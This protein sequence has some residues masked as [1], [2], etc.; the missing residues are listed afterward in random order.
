MN[1]PEKNFK[2]PDE[3]SALEVG[4]VIRRQD[5]DFL[6]YGFDEKGAFGLPVRPNLSPISFQ[7]LRDSGETRFS[8]AQ[9]FETKD[10][11]LR[12]N[13]N[14]RTRLETPSINEVRPTKAQ[15]FT[16]NIGIDF[17]N[18]IYQ[19]TFNTLSFGHDS[20]HKIRALLESMGTLSPETQILIL[21]LGRPNPRGQPT[22]E[23][24]TEFYPANESKEE[25]IKVISA[26]Y[27]TLNELKIR[28]KD[29]VL[30]IDDATAV[31]FR[32]FNLF[33]FMKAEVS[34]PGGAV[35]PARNLPGVGHPF[36]GLPNHPG[37]TQQECGAI[38]QRL[39]PAVLP[40]HPYRAPD[41]F[42]LPP[43]L[44]RRRHPVQSQKCLLRP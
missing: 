30:F 8:S 38:H 32:L 15:V 20:A 26:L 11:G 29:V 12:S 23:N 9:L 28:Q 42:G 19:G 3:N 10:Q 27:N 40:G 13:P 37:R 5:Q 1:L 17:T 33:H 6:V 31:F 24:I 34:S 35:L 43:R 14:F 16:G 39:F 36:P 21:S 41:A 44:H 4:S 22:L 2:I 25:A 7:R 18:P